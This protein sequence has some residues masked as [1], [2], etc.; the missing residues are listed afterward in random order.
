M[1]GNCNAPTGSPLLLAKSR[2]GP[3]VDHVHWHSSNSSAFDNDAKQA[4][5][6]NPLPDNNLADSI[7]VNS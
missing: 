4:N 3:T 1:H 7:E 6:K 2:R 5:S